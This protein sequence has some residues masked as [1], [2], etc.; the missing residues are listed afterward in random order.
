MSLFIT[1]EGGEG[2]GKSYQ[3]RALYRHLCRL[4]VGVVLTQEP[5]GTP[6]G[7]TIARILKQ[8]EGDI[9]PMAELMLFNASRAELVAGIIRPALADGQIVIC[10]RYTDSTMAYQGYGRGLDQK[11]VESLNLVATEGL[12][13]DL[14]IMLD[15]DISQGL[16]RK[17][18]D[19]RDR[20]EQEETAFHHRVRQ[21]YA[22]MA[23]AEPQRWLV[24]DASQDKKQVERLIWE[25]LSKLIS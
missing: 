19:K 3:S 5:G 8:K 11:V 21:G 7:L 24:L 14:T 13:P 10:D 9:S 12:K 18:P 22:E 20:F 6:L 25:R 23:A 16:A 15:F 2:S 17:N 4:G 1:F